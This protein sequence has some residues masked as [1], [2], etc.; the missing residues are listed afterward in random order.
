MKNITKWIKQERR[1][2]SETHRHLSTKA[3][4]VVTV[5]LISVLLNYLGNTLEEFI[6]AILGSTPKGNPI[7]TDG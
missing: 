2:I 7:N 1:K 5:I 6:C 3:D 4:N